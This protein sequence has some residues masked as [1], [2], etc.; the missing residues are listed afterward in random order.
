MRAVYEQGLYGPAPSP[1][2]VRTGLGRAWLNG[3]KN[4]FDI[5]DLSLMGS[6]P[7]WAFGFA[8]DYR[9]TV[10][11][12]ETYLDHLKPGGFLSLN[13]FIIPPPRAELRLLATIAAAAGNR[14][15]RDFPSHLAVAG[16]DNLTIVTLLRTDIDAIKAFCQRLRIDLCTTPDQP[17]R[18]S[19]YIKM[20]GD[21]YFRLPGTS[22]RLIRA[23]GS[24]AIIPS[25]YGLCV[26]KN[27]FFTII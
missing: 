1:D 22:S 4:A 18:G 14:G 9:F 21:D 6:L 15:I 5:I 27:L 2:R 12:F 8:E 16:W 11:A 10:E 26:M 25:M 13:L 20:Q 19:R 7:G 23:I 24:S 3:R 17:G